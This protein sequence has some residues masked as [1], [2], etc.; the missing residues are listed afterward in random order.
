[1]TDKEILAELK[2]AYEYLEDIKENGHQLRMAELYQVAEAQNK[3]IDIYSNLWEK[4]EEDITIKGEEDLT[5]G[6]EI[7][8]DYY[9]VGNDEFIS[10][11]DILKNGKEYEW[12]DDYEFLL[13]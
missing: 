10:K 8:S 11:T 5:I 6:K 13:K 3:L 4:T 9:E 1:M 12:W 7:Y 2:K